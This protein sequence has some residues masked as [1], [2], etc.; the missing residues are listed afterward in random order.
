MSVSLPFLA[1]VRVSKKAR[2]Y[3]EG[4][5]PEIFGARK[6]RTAWICR[7]NLGAP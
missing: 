4:D 7:M 3:W 6:L 2:T 5:S 1:V